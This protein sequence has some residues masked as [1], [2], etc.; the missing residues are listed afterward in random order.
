MLAK[1]RKA[2]LGNAL[3]AQSCIDGGIPL[4]IR[5]RDFRAFTEA[6]GLDLVLQRTDLAPSRCFLSQ[7]RRLLA[8]SQHS[9]S[10][11]TH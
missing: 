5:D 6:A 8:A 11:A 4:L 3:I 2:R 10:P 9:L 1:R 7:L